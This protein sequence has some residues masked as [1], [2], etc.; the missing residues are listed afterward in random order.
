MSQKSAVL[1]FVIGLLTTFGFAQGNREKMPDAAPTG[2]ALEVTFIKTNPPAYMTLN[3]SGAKSGGAWYSL[4]GR[5]P[6]FQTPPN[7]LPVR[8]V[9]IVPLLEKDVVK[10]AV[11]VFKGHKFHDREEAVAVYSIRENERISVKE[12]A[13]FGVEPFE[14][15]VVR[16][17][18]SATLLPSVINQTNSLQVTNIEPT[19]STLPAYKISFLNI[20]AKAVSAFAFETLAD[21]QRK[22]LSGMPQ[23]LQGEALIKAGAIYKR[24]FPNSLQNVKTTDGQP[25][26]TQPNQTIVISA[27]VFEDGSYEGDASRAAQFRAFTL[28]RKLQLKQMSDFSLENLDKQTT[29]LKFTMDENAF[30]DLLKEFPVLPEKEKTNLRMSVEIAANGVKREFLQA[31]EKVKNQPPDELRAWLATANESHRKWFARLR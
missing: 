17:A 13:N 27:V 21:N 24:Q 20:S 26:P 8:A 23:G 9:N 15:A 10:V 14:I 31:L 6:N 30:A 18:P 29:N 2:L 3:E 25:P 16:V 28:G 1:L 22:L 5:T 4:F 7:A 12:L 19:F 11:S